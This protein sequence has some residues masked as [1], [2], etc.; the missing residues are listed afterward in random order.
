MSDHFAKI[1][2]TILDSSIWAEDHP[3]V[4]LWF[5]MLLMSD[6]TGYIEAAVPGLAGRAHITLPEC[7]AA[8][9]KFQSPDLYSK[10]QE[11]DGRRVKKVD[12]GWQ[13]LNYQR[14]RD[15][16]TESQIKRNERQQR[17]REKRRLNVDGNVDS[18]DAN[19]D[20]EYGQRGEGRGERGEGKG[21]V[22]SKE[23]NNTERLPLARMALI[24]TRDQSIVANAV[25]ESLKLI[26][27][28]EI[29]AKELLGWQIKAGFAYWVT[30][31]GKNNN[32]VKLSLGRW[33]RLEKYIKMYDLETC[34]YAIDG[35]LIHP[36]MNQDGRTFHE[37]E[38]IFMN[39]PE[40]PGR[41]E[42]LSE[43]ARKK[44]RRPKHRLL[45]AHPRLEGHV[46]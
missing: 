4:R 45:K 22:P 41:V 33:A 32:R 43:H 26:G 21:V 6:S 31:M 34:L 30:K 23:G 2:A 25:L 10:D 28:T 29:V 12:R 27:Q 5:T 16:R 20:G 24:P 37:F 40:G 35:A 39:K 13:L 38:E 11:D 1:Y 36:D 9:E 14:Y 19:V 17:W 46:K 44:D 3:T 18:V 15:M 7:E 8:L 42:K